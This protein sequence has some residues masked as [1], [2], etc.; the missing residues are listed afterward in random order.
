M[1]FDKETLLR[2]LNELEENAG[3]PTRFLVALS[4]GLDSS[5]LLHALV[6]G[7]EQHNV[8]I[9]AIHIN[10]GLH[11]DAASWQRHC[12]A[13]AESLDVEFASERVMVDQESGA[14]PEAAAREARYAALRGYIDQG[15]WL[16]SAHHQDDQAETLLLN[17]MR[18]SGPTGL[19]GMK[20]ARH[21]AAGWLVRPLLDVS[22]KEL[23]AYAHG[24]GVGY[25]E[26]PSNV[27]TQYDRNF[28]RQEVLPL[29]ETRWHGASGRVRRSAELL[30]EADDLLADL[31]EIDGQAVIGS[32]G[33][34]K[35]SGLSELP[36]ARQRNLLRHMIMT[37]GLPLPGAAQLGQIL[38][39]LVPARADA[40][41]VVAWAGAMARRYRDQIYLMPAR[42]LSE[43]A[44]EA[45]TVDRNRVVLPAGLGTLV[46]RGGAEQGLSNAVIGRGLQLRFRVGGEEI[47]P[48]GQA[49]TRKLK[50]LL[51]EESVV[52]WMREHLPLLYCEDRLVAVADLWI[53]DDASGAPGTA[54]EWHNRPALY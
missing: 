40:Q 53:A 49:H 31:A 18:G 38:G 22:R 45:R 46:L 32:T 4:G 19:A 42:D 27:D 13:L 11:E 7:R 15:D 9:M 3:A 29:V 35:I 12:E 43:I 17:L 48:V 28:L 21:F 6:A 10:H 16:L 14:G 39:E 8:P 50:K 34:L 37:L 41:P 20:P 51:Q 52:P 33:T 44:G 1:S 24:Q 54:V 25:V 5:V 47:K 23:E 26:D 36:A 30:R 2:R